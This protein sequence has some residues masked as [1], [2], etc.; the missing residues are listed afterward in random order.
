MRT[1]KIFLASSEELAEERIRFGDFIR[2]LDDTYEQRGF[3]IKLSKWEDLPSGDDG[4]PKQEE[5]NAKVRECDMFVSLFYTVAGKYTQ[6][7]YA[8]AKSVQAQRGNPTIYV[9]YRELK[10]GEKED[11]S[12]TEFK[13]RLLNEIKQYGDKYVNSDSLQL[14]FVMQL[15]KI[16]NRQWSD[17]KVEN[18]SVILGD[19][20]IAKMDNLSFAAGNEDYQR[21]RQRLEEL[22]DLIEVARMKAEKDK[23]AYDK[24]QKYLNEANTLREQFDKQQ[25]FLL[26][27]AKRIAQLQGERINDRIRRAQE[28]LDYGRVDEALEILKDTEYD[29]EKIHQQLKQQKQLVE[30]LK[31][32]AECSINE[33][34]IKISTVMARAA[35]PIEERIAQAKSLYAQADT[36]AAEA[37]YDKEKYAKMLLDYAVFLECYD[38]YDESLNVSKR[39]LTLVEKVF[40]Y[41]NAKTAEAYAKIS[42]AYVGKGTL[43]HALKNIIRSSAIMERVYGTEHRD[44]ASSYSDIGYVYC[45]NGEYNRALEFYLKAYAIREK[46]FGTEHSDTAA[47]CNDIGLV[48]AEKCDYERAL[49]YSLKALVIREKV[50][51]IKH[52]DTAASYNNVGIV[53][54]EKGDN[55]RALEYYLK[56]LAIRENV[57]GTEHSDTAASYDNIGNIY[58]DKGDYDRAL[59]CYLK[60][61]EIREK[62][63]GTKH[64]ET[65]D[66]YN[67]IGNIY[68][69]KMDY[70]NALKYYTKT[71]N[72]WKKV[73]GSRDE[74][75]I[76]M[77]NN[78]KLIKSEIEDN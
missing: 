23:A 43:N 48:Y 5:Y 9:Y 54:A 70:N 50:L 28:A 20:V 67:N 33:L 55:D 37:D 59:E 58:Y 69:E 51:G 3:R 42:F 12:L 30:N 27:T 38:L 18:G 71:Y 68:D 21:M 45:C 57:L 7:E 63:L 74:R 19:K 10:E 34:L 6:E 40:G 17:L 73:Y 60:A 56:A 39:H 24:L 52:R 61:L 29:A 8:V 64:S 2:Q 32:Q 35:T 4:K 47:S 77:K 62:L 53:Y 66:S 15:L 14:K 75:T 22:E 65:A 76:L 41:Y 26:D 72:I 46:V 25:D 1:I 44:T 78:I 49:E 31:H 16:E 36:L 11:P 13:S